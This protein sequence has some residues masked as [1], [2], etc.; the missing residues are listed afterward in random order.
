MKDHKYS[1]TQG[2][3]CDPNT[4]PSINHYL[5]HVTLGLGRSYKLSTAIV[6]PMHECKIK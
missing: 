4:W 1:P 5:S 3:K 6:H 2:S